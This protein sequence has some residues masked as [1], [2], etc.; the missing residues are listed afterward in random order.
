MTACDMRRIGLSCDRFPVLLHVGRRASASRY[1]NCFSKSSQSLTPSRTTSPGTFWG[2][3]WSLWCSLPPHPHPHPHTPPDPI[4][5][6]G[7]LPYPEEA[8]KASQWHTLPFLSSSLTSPVIRIPT[9]EDT[10]CICTACVHPPTAAGF[11]GRLEGRGFCCCQGLFF[12]G[13]LHFVK[14]VLSYICAETTSPC[15]VLHAS[16]VS[17]SA[18]P[19]PPISQSGPR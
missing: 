13:S 9:S 15:W 11:Q 10:P 12:S 16:R 8:S 7:P 3:S 1:R 4:P 2:L 5:V 19:A 17:V 14:Q 6:C 18:L